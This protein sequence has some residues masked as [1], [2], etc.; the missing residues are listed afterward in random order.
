[1][2][3]H[4]KFN[5]KFRFR[6]LLFIILIVLSSVFLSFSSGGFVVNF[7]NVGFTILSTIEEGIAKVTFFVKDTVNAAKKLA[8]LNK[9][10]DLLVEKLKDYEYFKN[11]KIS[12]T[13][14]TIE[15]QNG[16]D[17]AP[18]NLYYNSKTIKIK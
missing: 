17:I 12:E 5:F 8:V 7:K 9:E 1:M 10:Y 11:V 2:R 4:K 13:G 3:K 15:W 14:I 6:E 16:E 18:E